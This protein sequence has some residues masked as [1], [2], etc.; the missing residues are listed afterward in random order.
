MKRAILTLFVVLAGFFL[1]NNFFTMLNIVRIAPNVLLV[2]TCIFGFL[3]GQKEGVLV[4]LLSGLLMDCFFG[5]TLGFYSIIYMCLGYL[6]GCFHRFFY[7][8]NIIIPV[9]ICGVSDLL[10]GC[11]IFVFRFALR[12]RLNFKFYLSTIMIPELLY[13]IVIALL[14]FGIL[15]AINHKIEEIEKRSAERFV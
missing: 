15:S 14:A 9:F 5:A 2:I 10:Y 8:D 6:N 3:R 7:N 4:G 12:N 11:Y 1:Q 13:T